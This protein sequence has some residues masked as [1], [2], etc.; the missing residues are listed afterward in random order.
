MHAAE[1]VS[2]FPK[3]RQYV[4]GM[5]FFKTDW[6]END[7]REDYSDGSILDIARFAG[8][9]RAWF[10]EKRSNEPIASEPL[11]ERVLNYMWPSLCE[12]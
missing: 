3:S 5:Y 1:T 7:R 8:D 4:D 10:M 2:S 11:K 12:W 9:G 6:R